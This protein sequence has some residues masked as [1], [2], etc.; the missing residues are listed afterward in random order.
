MQERFLLQL[1][2]GGFQRRA[3]GSHRQDHKVVGAMRVGVISDTPTS[4]QISQ[5][6]GRKISKHIC[7]HSHIESTGRGRHSSRQGQH[8]ACQHVRRRPDVGSSS[9]QRSCPSL[10]LVET[11]AGESVTENFMGWPRFKQRTHI[12]MLLA[13]AACALLQ[14]H[15]PGFL[16]LLH[17][18]QALVSLPSTQLPA[19]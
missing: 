6:I 1:C 10:P 15:P 2:H 9:E 12:N 11:Y 3:W 7:G 17:Q 4:C 18:F 14:L 13:F 19:S 5:R 16:T 8:K